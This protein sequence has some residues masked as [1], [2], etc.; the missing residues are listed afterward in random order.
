MATV[1]GEVDIRASAAEVLDVIADLPSY[2]HWSSVH[3]RAKVD[4]VGPDGRPSRATM[5]VTAA[6]LADVQVLDYHWSKSGV[7]WSL[8]KA[9]QQRDQHGS[10]ALAEHDGVTH[11]SYDLDINPSIPVPGFVVR[12]VMKKAVTA[13]TEGLRDRVQSMH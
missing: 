3:K 11:V 9:T 7:S 10:Y 4:E 6:G 1:H 12:Q 5:T 2:P 8:V 13:A